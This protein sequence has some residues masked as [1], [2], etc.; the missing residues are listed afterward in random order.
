[1][2]ARRALARRLGLPVVATND[3]HVHSR[4][5]GPLQ[6]ALVAIRVHAT[7]D[8]CEAERRGNREHV[9]KRPAEMA[10]LFA[11]VPEAIAGHRRDRRPHR[12]ST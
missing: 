6:D 4:R 9:L 2:R 7:L 3:V 1:M 10:A 12:R 8:A 11:D 5:R